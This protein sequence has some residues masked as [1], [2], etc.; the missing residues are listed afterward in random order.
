MIKFILLLIIPL[1]LFAKDGPNIY[2]DLSLGEQDFTEYYGPNDP[3][4]YRLR[5]K[6]KAQFLDDGLRKYYLELNSNTHLFSLIHFVGE[7]LSDDIRCP[8]YQLEKNLAYIRYLY[9]L[10]S[11]SYLFEGLKELYVESYN[12]GYGNFCSLE[13][14]KTFGQC[15]ATNID[16]A[17]FIKRAEGNYLKDFSKLRLK[18]MKHAQKEEWI[19]KFRQKKKDLNVVEAR[20]QLFCIENGIECKNIDDSTLKFAFQ[21]SCAQ[22]QYTLIN[23]CSGFDKLYGLSNVKS[24][25]SLILK[26]EAFKNINKEGFGK[27]CLKRYSRLFSERESHSKVL[28]TIFPRVKKL[29]K[30]DKR[31]YQQGSL[32][33]SGS[34]KQ[35]DAKGLKGFL[36]PKDQGKSK[37]MAEREKELNKNLAKIKKPEPPPV[38]EVFILKNPTSQNLNILALAVRANSQGLNSKKK[39]EPQFKKMEMKRF[40]IGA[41]QVPIEMESF[42]RDYIISRSL[43][44]ETLQK[45]KAYAEYEI[46]KKLKNDEGMGK[47]ENPFS[48][49]YLKYLLENGFDTALENIVKLYKG[50][51]YVLNDLIGPK[52]ISYIELKKL[53][54]GW[55]IFILKQKDKPTKGPKFKKK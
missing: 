3:T 45:L 37:Q 52:K 10:I 23:I 16:M 38:E 1:T 28:A 43:D 32:F 4:L 20:I 2:E 47:R 9:R 42:K 36:F 48:L 8:N 7:D 39:I 44:E 14:D 5:Y 33:I 11:I 31:V 34:F 40:L 26:S 27:E 25:Y 13:W 30:D 22:D 18:R 54:L 29:M 50:R 6:E 19:E 17:N 41:D 46:I 53:D 24:A 55:Q 21:L 35:F 49:L 15:R 12:L 51:F